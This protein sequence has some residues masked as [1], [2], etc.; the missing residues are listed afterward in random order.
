[1]RNTTVMITLKLP[2]SL[3]RRLDAGA[4][5]KR[6]ARSAFVRDAIEAAL[7]QQEGETGNGSVLSHCRDLAGCVDG[8]A[9][10]SYATRHMRGFGR[11]R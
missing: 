9:D 2:D 3:A 10:L 4:R 5:R 8:A 6:T 11:R 7:R 1:M